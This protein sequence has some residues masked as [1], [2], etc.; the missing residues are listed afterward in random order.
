ME[1]KAREIIS[2]LNGYFGGTGEVR[3]NVRRDSCIFTADAA[4]RLL[5]YLRLYPGCLVQQFFRLSASCLFLFS[6]F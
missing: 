5:Y 6:F 2:P 1:I 4:I 3:L